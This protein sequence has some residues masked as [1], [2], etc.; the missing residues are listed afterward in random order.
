[1]ADQIG[2]LGSATTVTI[3]TTAVYT[4]PSA[5]AAKVKIMWMGKAGADSNGDLAF[6]VNGIN[7]ASWLNLVTVEYFHSC[8]TLLIT[9]GS[10]TAEPTGLTALLTV[11]P[12]PFEWYLSAGDIV[13]YTIATTAMNAINVQ[14]VGTEI[15]V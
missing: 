8:T 13:S 4:V 6:T 2:V 3:G 9:D 11:A 12:A 5:K 14:V 7:V 1:M 10:I 15:D